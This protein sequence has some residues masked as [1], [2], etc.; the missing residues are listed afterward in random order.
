MQKLKVIQGKLEE[1]NKD[2]VGSILFLEPDKV[3]VKS[4]PAPSLPKEYSDSLNGLKIGFSP[5]WDFSPAE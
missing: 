5:S 4:G 2:T 3:T 1:I